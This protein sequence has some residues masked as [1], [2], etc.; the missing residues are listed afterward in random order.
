MNF[1]FD[2][3]PDCVFPPQMAKFRSLLFSGEGEAPSC[4]VD[5]YRPPQLLKGRQVRASFK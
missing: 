1:L 2:L 4:M 3:I 5:N